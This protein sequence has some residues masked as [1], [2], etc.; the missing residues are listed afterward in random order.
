MQQ[1]RDG[2][3]VPFAFPLGRT[4][5]AR[6]GSAAVRPRGR[7]RRLFAT[8][9][10]LAFLAGLASAPMARAQQGLGDDAEGVEF[11][12]KLIRPVLVE[13]CLAC[14]GAR[15]KK[16]KGGLVLEDRAA[17]L[18]GG[19]SGPVIVPGDP[20]S[21]LLIEAIRYT[22]E[23][24]RMPPKGRLAPP[25]VAAFE[26][27]VK[28]ARPAPASRAHDIVKS[29]ATRPAGPATPSDHWAFQP[30]REPLVPS[31]SGSALGPIDAFLLAELEKRGLPPAPAADRRALIRRATF[32]LTGLPPRPEEVESF[33]ADRSPDAF[34]RVVDRL[35]ASPRYGE[36]WARTLARFGS[37]YR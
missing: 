9:V 20:E 25:E 6:N 3:P 5:K 4:G 33:V 24:L 31:S 17:M 27:W 29:T 36:R 30:P 7:S 18:K 21:S 28:R 35:L 14:H 37:L 23:S 15:V 12:E 32:D 1:S 19:D 8:V 22:G 26:S 34:A 13:R 16:P 11:F 2:A 10:G